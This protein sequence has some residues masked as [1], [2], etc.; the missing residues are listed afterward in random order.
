MNMSRNYLRELRE[1]LR[2][3]NGRN[4]S[5]IIMG[6]VSEMRKDLANESISESRKKVENGERR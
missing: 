5:E 4:E 6:V 3:N 1:A 2:S